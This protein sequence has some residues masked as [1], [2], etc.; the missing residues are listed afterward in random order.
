MYIKGD[1]HLHTTSSDGRLSP[2][3]LVNL[4]KNKGLDV[5]AITD[6]D[7]T[8]GVEEGI[9][10][11]NSIG[12]K[13][14]PGIELSTR[15]ND[16]SIHILGYFRDNSFKSDY[17]QNYL[18]EIQDYRIVRAEKIVNNLK[19]FF[20]IE[21]NFQKLLHANHSVIAR[22]HIA[23]AIIDAGYPYD[24][25]YIFNKF[26]SSDSPAYVPNKRISIAEGIEILKSV[27]AVISL[28]HPTLIKKS[29]VEEIIKQD[30]DCIEAV[31]PLN[32]EGEE[33]FFRYLAKKYKKI[34]TAGSDYHGVG[35]EDHKHGYI[36]TSTLIGEELNIFLEK[37]KPL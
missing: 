11:G 35:E 9:R 7:N 33:E 14:I 3:E 1:L 25:K 20:N 10:E 29:P 26:L 27:K 15:Y 17:F 4:A 8:F 36:G 6:H 34:I 12:I 13:V 19:K 21:L 23:K 22:P 31:Y 37:L 16:E 5:I 2:S 30:F 32:K 18:K 24:F 28:A